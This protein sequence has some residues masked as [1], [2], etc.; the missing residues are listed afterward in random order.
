MG[1]TGSL[2]CVAMC[3]A[4]QRT[5]IGAGAASGPGPLARDLWFQAGRTG[6][7]AALGAAAGLSG[8]WL[9]QAMR[10]QPV[11]TSAWASLN[12]L[13]LMLGLTLLMLG[14]Q[15][16]WLDALGQRLWQ[17]IRPGRRA[18]VVSWPTARASDRIAA[19]LA[20][21][22]A[23]LATAATPACAGPVAR[24]TPSP[25]VRRASLIARGALW[26]LLP[27]GLLYSALALAILAGDPLQSAVVMAVFA[28]G[29]T[30]GL[31]GFQAGLSR[32]PALARRLPVAGGPDG[33]LRLGLRIN[34]A[35]L[36]VMA[37]IALVAVLGGHPNPFCAPPG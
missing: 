18:A 2:H 11:F 10:W 31:L 30:T 14:R 37:A 6:G 27:C 34:G 5:A 17:T 3:A 16:Y 9:L 19:G 29:T 13:L 8:Q 24:P 26:A 32:L 1:A 33:A 15:P 35:L 28:L 7:Y 20:A 23:A 4:L 22:P 25:G 36:S 21:N 12:A